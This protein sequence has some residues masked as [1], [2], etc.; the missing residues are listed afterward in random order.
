MMFRPAE[1]ITETIQLFIGLCLVEFHMSID[2]NSL[3]DE[4]DEKLV[5][6]IMGVM[7]TRSEFFLRVFEAA[8]YLRFPLNLVHS[9]D[10]NAVLSS[11]EGEVEKFVGQQ[12]EQELDKI[13]KERETKSL[14]LLEFFQQPSFSRIKVQQKFITLLAYI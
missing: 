7:E 12:I 13:F 9:K 5:R 8:V 11:N 3:H 1:N 6:E 2:K 10:L 4:V 14:Q